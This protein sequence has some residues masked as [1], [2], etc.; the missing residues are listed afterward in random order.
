M[1]RIA[2][3]GDVDTGL[4]K[5]NL[6]DRQI[7]I[8]VR[9]NDKSR[10]NLER[11]KLLDRARHACGPVPLMNVADV[12]LG[13]GPAQ[14]T[15]IDRSRNITLNADLDRPRARRRAEGAST[16]LPS[17][18]NLP[19]GV[20]RMRTG[21]ARWHHRDLQPVRPRDGHRRACIYAVLV[22]LFHK[23]IQPVTI[24]TALPPSAAGAFVA[25]LH[26]RLRRSRSTR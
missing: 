11:L 21:D 8:R 26:L 15:R 4:A 22:L 10:T 13:A 16:T 24:L 3:S 23:F 19:A 18:Q 14:I 25:L 1:T 2:T 20:R 7:P 9:L 5:F 17:M 6:D 12:S